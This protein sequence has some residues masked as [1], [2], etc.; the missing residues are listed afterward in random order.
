[1]AACVGRNQTVFSQQ[2]FAPDINPIV[3]ASGAAVQQQQRLARA[4]DF[5]A[6]LS[7]VQVYGGFD[8]LIGHE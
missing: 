5:V 3:V 2:L 8:A 1:M 6:K 4:L 7:A